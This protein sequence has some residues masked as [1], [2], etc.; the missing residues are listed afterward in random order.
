MQWLPSASMHVARAHTSACAVGAGSRATKLHVIG[1]IGVAGEDKDRVLDS[2]EMFDLETKRWSALPAMMS[3]RAHAGACA[4]L[5]KTYVVGGSDKAGTPLATVTA[6]YAAS[7]IWVSV[8]SMQTARSD[9]SVCTHQGMASLYSFHSGLLC[10]P[11]TLPSPALLSTAATSC[12]V[13]FL[14][15]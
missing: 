14:I 11:Y 4:C 5:D 1:G 2:A 3:P 6:L 15:F 12:F 7:G 8:P 9:V 13:S 10:R